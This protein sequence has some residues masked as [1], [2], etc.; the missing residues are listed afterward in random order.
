MSNW[1]KVSNTLEKYQLFSHEWANNILNFKNVKR[2][3]NEYLLN[4][5]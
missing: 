5:R 2:Y 3:L 4:V 1:E